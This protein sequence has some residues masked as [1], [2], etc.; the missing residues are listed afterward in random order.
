MCWVRP[1]SSKAA[2]AAPEIGSG[3]RRSS[4]MPPPARRRPPAELRAYDL[5]LQARALSE[6]F[7]P[8]AQHRARRVYEQAIRLDPGPARGWI[9]LAHN[10]M[11]RAQNGPRAGRCETIPTGPRRSAWSSTP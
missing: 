7:T 1:M 11:L 4:W 9:G 10:H 6:T 2:C 5:F 8:D 3:S